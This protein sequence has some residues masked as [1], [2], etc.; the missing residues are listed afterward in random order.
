MLEGI[1]KTTV[2]YTTRAWY[3]GRLGRTLVV[4]ILAMI[5]IAVFVGVSSEPKLL[6]EYRNYGIVSGIWFTLIIGLFVW[7]SVLTGLP[8]LKVEFHGGNRLGRE[9]AGDH[10]Y[11]QG[12]AIFG[13]VAIASN[14]GGKKLSLEPKMV[15][16]E[17]KTGKKLYESP[18]M[19]RLPIPEARAEQNKVGEFVGKSPPYCPD[20]LVLE[21]EETKKVRLMFL[22]EMDLV[23]RIGVDEHDT[24]RVFN[25]DY[26]LKFVDKGLGI[27]F[28]CVDKGR[29]KFECRWLRS[30]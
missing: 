2:K 28:E 8:R 4:V 15:L 18:L 13:F 1:L 14:T 5:V 6:T 20:L 11:H 26:S 17:K 27:I 10:P 25:A 19:P 23:D 24:I 16:R 22:V 7:L 21:V 30:N 3:M 29:N 9:D 12:G